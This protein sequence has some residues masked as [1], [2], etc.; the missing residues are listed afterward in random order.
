MFLNPGTKAESYQPKLAAAVARSAGAL[1]KIWIVE[2]RDT[3]SVYSNGLQIRS[4]YLTQSAPRN[5]RTFARGSLQAS[6][7]K[8]LPAG[9]VYHT[10]ESLLMPLEAERNQSLIR[11]RGD[12]LNYVRNE[13]LYN[14]V[15]DRFGQVFQVVPESMVAHHAGHSVWADASAVYVDLNESFIGVA[16]EASTASSFEPNA[17]QVRAGR[18]LTDLLRAQYAIPEFRCVTHAQVSVNPDNMRVGLHTDWA[19]NFPFRALGLAGGYSLP[20]PAI[21]VFGFDYD[22]NFLESIGGWPWQGMVVAEEHLARDAQARGKS[23]GAYRQFLQQQYRT[24]RSHYHGRTENR[25]RS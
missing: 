5:Y 22:P 23:P 19:A 24:L 20:V 21:E 2:R 13:R 15:I 6:S 17:A 8:Q 4:D 12:L 7:E 18:M 11:N 14:F 16:F 9:I 10:T 25:D 1:E 3:E